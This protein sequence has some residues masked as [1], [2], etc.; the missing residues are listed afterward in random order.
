[1]NDSVSHVRRAFETKGEVVCK[2][3]KQDGINFFMNAAYKIIP[4]ISLIKPAS[5]QRQSKVECKTENKI[6]LRSI[7]SC[8][9]EGSGLGDLTASGSVFLS[10]ALT[11]FETLLSSDSPE[12]DPVSASSSVSCVC[13]AQSF[14]L[15]GLICSGQRL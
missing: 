7:S 1:M 9:L 12:V 11:F 2:V 13:P 15:S 5:H 4:P 6:R 8:D 14:H 10:L 3:S